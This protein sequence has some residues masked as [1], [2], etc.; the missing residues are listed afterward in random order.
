MSDI[1]S[2]PAIDILDSTKLQDASACRRKFM[3]AHVFGWRS[4]Y[5]NN[6]LVFGSAWHLA[7]AYLLEKGYSIENIGDAYAIFEEEYRKDF[8]PD[9]DDMF[10]PKVPY[11]VLT[12]LA[13]YVLQYKEIDGEYKTLHIE[14]AGSVPILYGYRLHFKLDSILQHITS[15]MYSSREHKTGSRLSQ[16][17]RDQ[18]CSKIQTGT[19]Q[20]VL[21]CMYDKELVEGISI[22]G[23]IFTSGIKKAGKVEFERVPVRRSDLMM[24]VWLHNVSE[25]AADISDDIAE[26]RE[27]FNNHVRDEVLSLFPMNTETCGGYNGCLYKD[28]CTSWGNPLRYIDSIPSGFEERFWNPIE[29]RSTAREIIDLGEV[30]EQEATAD[31]VL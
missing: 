22:N 17:W 6:H 10:F 12:N 23:A 2:N 18:W 8:S 19:Y 30:K 26:L 14:V 15:G 3:F 1:L 9:T 13:K 16:A 29:E 20:H 24:E 25:L 4:A 31:S 11:V 27:D 21:M 7:M 28:M 5:P